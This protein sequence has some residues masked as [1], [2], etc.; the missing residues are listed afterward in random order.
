MPEDDVGNDLL[1]GWIVLHLGSRL[2]EVLVADRLL[3]ALQV[4]SHETVPG[5]VW[6]HVLALHDE[7]LLGGDAHGTMRTRPRPNTAISSAVRSTSSSR[8]G[9]TQIQAARS[10]AAVIIARADSAL[11]FPHGP[12]ASATQIRP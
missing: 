4:F 2:E 8:T 9:R 1:E 10:V 7:N 5:P 12:S 6:K 11:G 3:M